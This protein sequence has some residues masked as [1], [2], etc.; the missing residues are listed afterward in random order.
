MK[1]MDYGL[2]RGCAEPEGFACLFCEVLTF[3]TLHGSYVCG[4]CE[5]KIKP[6]AALV[7]LKKAGV[8]CVI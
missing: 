1:I 7:M 5:Y 3:N 2:A 8:E 6:S 4:R